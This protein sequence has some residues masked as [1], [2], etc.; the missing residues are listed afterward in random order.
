MALE[1]SSLK[2]LHEDFDQD[3]DG[4]ELEPYLSVF[5]NRLP[6]EKLGETHEEKVMLIKDLVELFEQVDVNG[7]GSMEWDEFTGY[8]IDSGMAATKHKAIVL[9]EL[10]AEAKYRDKQ[11]HGAFISK[12]LWF[13]EVSKLCVIGHGKKCLEVYEAMEEAGPRLLHKIE[14]SAS[15]AAGR[16]A[17]EAGAVLASE[18]LPRFNLIAMSTS[19]LALSF[20]Q[21]RY[22]RSTKSVPFFRK[23]IHT[24]QA[25]SILRWCDWKNV[26]LLFS[27]G[28]L[29]PTVYGW[30]V[31]LKGSEI[32][33]EQT[34]ALE[35][36]KDIITDICLSTGFGINEDF[37]VL[38]TASMDRTINVWGIGTMADRTR[39]AAKSHRKTMLGHDAGIL[40]LADCK[41]GRTIISCGFDYDAYVWDVKALDCAPIIKLKGHRF[42]LRRCHF[43]NGR[44]ITI[45]KMGWVK[46]WNLTTDLGAGQNRCLQTVRPTNKDWK[47]SSTVALYPHKRLVFAAQKLLVFDTVRVRPKELPIASVIYNDISMTIATATG[48]TV[49]LW[50]AATA[51]MAHE[52]HECMDHEISTM[53]LDD[54]KRKFILADI[55][56]NVKCF[57]YLNGAMMKDADQPHTENVSAMIYSVEDRCLITVGWDR[58]LIVLDEEPGE[59]DIPTLR[60][61]ADAH[62]NDISAAAFSHPLSLIATGDSQGVVKMWDFQFLTFEGICHSSGIEVTCMK[63][64]DPY[65]ILLVA[66]FS[67]QIHVYQVRPAIPRHKLLGT[68][69]NS[70]VDKFGQQATWPILTMELVYNEDGGSEIV[71]GVHEGSLTLVCGDEGGNICTLDL[72]GFLRDSNITACDPEKLPI[73]RNNYYARRMFERVGDGRKK[74][75]PKPENDNSADNEASMFADEIVEKSTTKTTVSPLPAILTPIAARKPGESTLVYPQP[76]TTR[77]SATYADS[78]AGESGQTPAERTAKRSLSL[79]KIYLHAGNDAPEEQ[80][81]LASTPA[82][83]NKD[84]FLE[85]L[86]KASPI[87]KMPG[88]RLLHRFE[89]HQSRIKTLSVT[90]SPD[91]LL[92]ASDDMTCRLWT[93]NGQAKG[94]LTRG[95]DADA[96]RGAR[97]KVWVSPVDGLAREMEKLKDAEELVDAVK[98]FE[99]EQ[100]AEEEEEERKREELE[101]RRRRHE[102]AGG[103]LAADLKR[104]RER[105]RLVDQLEGEKTWVLSDAELGRIQAREAAQEAIKRRAEKKAAKRSAE[106]AE[107]AE[108]IELLSDPPPL[109]ELKK[110]RMQSTG[111][112]LTPDDPENWDLAGM[113]KQKQL[114]PRLYG[115]RHRAKMLEEEKV[116]K[117][118]GERDL[119][120]PS[121]WLL[122]QYKV[123]SNVVHQLE[124]KHQRV[125]DSIA[126]SKALLRARKI[127]AEKQAKKRRRKP[128]QK[129]QYEKDQMEIAKE[130]AL[131]RAQTSGMLPTNE[132]PED[133]RK[134]AMASHKL[135]SIVNSFDTLIQQTTKDEAETIKLRKARRDALDATKRKKKK[136]KKRKQKAASKKDS[137]GDEKSREIL[138]EELEQEE[139]RLRIERVRLKKKLHFGTYGAKYVRHMR[140][141]LKKLTNKS[142]N[143]HKIVLEDFLAMERKDAEQ[144]QGSGG[145]HMA[146]HMESMFKSIDVGGDGMVDLE[147]LI[148]ILFKKTNKSEREDITDYIK[149]EVSPRLGGDGKRQLAPEELEELHQ[150]FKMWDE[151]ASGSLEPEEIKRVL[152]YD[153]GIEPHEL[154]RILADADTNKD[155]VIDKKE[156]VEMMR[157]LFDDNLH[158]TYTVEL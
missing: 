105:E 150:I 79:P 77:Q 18:Y 145:S 118:G 24:P 135:A 47:P 138:A 73:N 136:K 139:E 82:T 17:V 111:C 5:L 43:I 45:D 15:L 121:E 90:A 76:N 99:K 156:F 53:V 67:A 14:S 119:L 29:V 94:I 92:T 41:D 65:P 84:R 61:V 46:Y 144:S 96:S 102:A 124:L 28:G 21:E 107:D 151:D 19:D 117:K 140:H 78:D 113:N 63:F 57:N 89:A 27:S 129:K 62:E 39:G 55:K 126:K 71:D 100:A 16:E 85:S 3:P 134:R 30:S 26:G 93:L 112:G 123:H 109:D 49:K 157:E 31:R 131:R 33:C 7:D 51:E 50:D 64:V 9:S 42:P 128:R 13:Q 34:H 148:F 87:K 88:I 10:Y 1:A 56:G 91:I 86:A 68:F 106:E 20:F 80:V 104:E 75:K 60:S 83:K 95:E 52:F 97:K 58:K 23:R 2:A 114:Y 66:D 74:K 132:T 8:C 48:T 127:E 152:P 146:D 70:W 125:K 98:E 44:G 54:R 137:E 69:L 122:E 110:L 11:L 6:K 25:Q 116:A 154:A 36:H 101:E 4:L 108:M 35:M 143:K 155:G 32:K 130:K 38:S 133:A 115:E 147:D 12:L 22:A 59:D 72:G 40:C 141:V 37:C 120:K 81:I 149:M 158:K 103:A 142:G 153:C